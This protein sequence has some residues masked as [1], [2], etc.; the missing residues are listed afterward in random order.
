VSKRDEDTERWKS[1]KSRRVNNRRKKKC[2]KYFIDKS[3][4]THQVD[5]TER[6]KRV[7]RKKKLQR[8]A[9]GELKQRDVRT[10]TKQKEELIL[11]LQQQQQ[12][13]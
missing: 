8:E 11:L 9:V 13:H 5:W 2:N 12:D 1:R 4:T 10:E 3:S 6:V 7:N